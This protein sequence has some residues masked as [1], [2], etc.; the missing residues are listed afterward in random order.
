M[1][2]SEHIGT[3]MGVKNC[4]IKKCCKLEAFMVSFSCYLNIEKLADN[5]KVFIF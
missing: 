5:D 2:S 1:S 4:V 3:G